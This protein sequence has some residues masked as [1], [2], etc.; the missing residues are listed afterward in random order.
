MYVRRYM[1]VSPYDTRKIFCSKMNYAYV[2]TEGD[3]HPCIKIMEVSKY[4][5]V[6]YSTVHYSVTVQYSTVRKIVQS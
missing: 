3:V 4:C 5:T 6:Q 2:R 1:N